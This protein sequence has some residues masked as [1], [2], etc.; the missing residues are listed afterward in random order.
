MSKDP[1]FPKTGTLL[2]EEEVSYRHERWLERRGFTDELKEIQK[3][4]SFGIKYGGD[5]TI[6]R[7][8]S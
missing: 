1:I 3:R 8:Q 7:R 6:E 5:R 2:L 4:R